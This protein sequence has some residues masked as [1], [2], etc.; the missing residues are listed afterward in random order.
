MIL[1]FAVDIQSIQLLTDGQAQISADFVAHLW[2]M[3]GPNQFVKVG[4][5]LP[6]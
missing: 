1:F 4:A 5:S 6:I 2:P 3:S